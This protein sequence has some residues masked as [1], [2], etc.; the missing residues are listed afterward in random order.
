MRKPIHADRRDRLRRLL[1]KTGADGLLVTH[2]AN[3]TY[4][5]GFT[6]DSSYLLLTPHDAIMLSDGRYTQQL[7]EECPDLDM[8]IRQPGIEMLPTVVKTVGAAKVATLAIEGDSMTVAFRPNWRNQL[9]QL[10]IAPTRIWSRN[11]GR[12][13]I[14]R[15]STRSGGD[16]SCG[17]GVCRGPGRLAARANGEANRRRTGVPDSPVRREGLQFHAH[18]RRRAAR[19][20]AARDGCRTIGSPTA[21]LS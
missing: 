16:R 13:K 5:T 10:A 20:L 14:R 2:P 12:S 3:V 6:G 1:R 9:P 15:R 7:A 18:R 21:T 4:L 17:A 8:E 11:C 19:S